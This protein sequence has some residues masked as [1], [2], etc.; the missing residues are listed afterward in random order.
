LLV[1]THIQSTGL[2]ETC[3]CP[4]KFLWVLPKDLQK[5]P[6]GLLFSQNIHMHPPA[7]SH[8]IPQE[9]NQSLQAILRLTE[10]KSLTLGEKRIDHH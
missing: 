9:V 7:F 3:L 10:T 5:C 6:F 4:V 1:A 2:L 8:R